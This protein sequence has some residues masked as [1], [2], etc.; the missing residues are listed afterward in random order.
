[1]A[2]SDWCHLPGDVCKNNLFGLVGL[3]GF[4]GLVGV[5]RL[6]GL[7][8]VVRLIG[9]V[10]LL[11]INPIRPRSHITSTIPVPLVRNLPIGTVLLLPV[12][13]RLIHL[14][15]DAA[16]LQK[17]AFLPLYKPTDKNVALMDEGDSDVSLGQVLLTRTCCLHHL[18]NGMVR[19]PTFRN[20]LAK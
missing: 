8:G 16:L 17:V 9:L 18:V 2:V 20:V 11:P 4:Y 1:M 3:S 19:S 5:V 7:V 15:L 12:F 6:I 14:L 10:G 13:P